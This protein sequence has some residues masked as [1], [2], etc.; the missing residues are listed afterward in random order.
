MV[1]KTISKK[2]G[3]GS[4][5]FQLRLPDGMRKQLAEVAEREGRSMNVVI[6][7]ALQMYF[8]HER[9]SAALRAQLHAAGPEIG[10]STDAKGLEDRFD[11][12]DRKLTELIE[13][14]DTSE[15]VQ[16]LKQKIK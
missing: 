4:D 10:A 15:L 2:T 3:P 1:K 13:K 9:Q 8:E 12:L 7:T 11:Q 16:L 6:V 5:Q 14:A